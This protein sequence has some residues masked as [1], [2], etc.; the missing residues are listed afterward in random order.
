M[1]PSWINFND[2]YFFCSNI[3]FMFLDLTEKDEEIIWFKSF[4]FR[5]RSWSQ[6]TT[7]NERNKQQLTEEE[8][9]R[10]RFRRRRRS[11]EERSA[12]EE[13]Q[14]LGQTEVFFVRLKQKQIYFIVHLQED[15]PQVQLVFIC[16]VQVNRTVKRS[17]RGEPIWLTKKKERK[18]EILKLL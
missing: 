12:A 6:T 17:G 3:Y 13:H 5:L 1:F 14:P 8:T 18:Q 7:R 11:S 9:V 15:V 10:R 4:I 16:R 2:L